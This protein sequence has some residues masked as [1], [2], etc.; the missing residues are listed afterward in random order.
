MG[1]IL[2]LWLIFFVFV[3]APVVAV[4]LYV[5]VWMCG[6]AIRRASWRVAEGW[7]EVA[8]RR[9]GVARGVS[10]PRQPALSALDGAALPPPETPLPQVIRTCVHCGEPISDFDNICL[11]CGKLAEP[12]KRA[13]VGPPR[14]LV[15]TERE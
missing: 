15:P 8:E 11:G 7:F 5:L 13:P 1:G 14:Y 6:P 2:G 3:V 9:P 12:T 4:E 10:S